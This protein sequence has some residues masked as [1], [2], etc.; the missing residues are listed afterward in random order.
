MM[1]ALLVAVLAF[2]IAAPLRA[3]DA[4][5]DAITLRALLRHGPWP[6]PVL[7]D[8]SNR[9]S[10]NA[11][12]IAL[13]QRLFADPRLSRDGTLSCAACHVPNGSF[14]DARER[15]IG[16]APLLRNTPTLWNVGLQ[17]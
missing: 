17:H 12:A 10:G 15:G 3:E 14:T 2:V 16:R 1:R 8:P 7:P 9:A 13:G 4:K 11:A 5:P 6:Q